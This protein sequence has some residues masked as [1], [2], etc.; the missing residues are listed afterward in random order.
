MGSPGDGEGDGMVDLDAI[1]GFA[2][3]LRQQ[4]VAVTQLLTGEIVR[5]NNLALE[6][7]ALRARVARMEAVLREVEWVRQMDYDGGTSFRCRSCNAFE[8]Q[9]HAA[10]CE[11]VAAM[12]EA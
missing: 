4:V 1:E 11:W 7:V 3:G 5:A 12:G 9:P 6:A 8:P 10:G 2:D